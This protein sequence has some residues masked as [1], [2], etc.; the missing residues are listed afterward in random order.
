MSGFSYSED[1]EVGVVGVVVQPSFWHGFHCG[2]SL[3]W[4]KKEVNWGNQPH[5]LNDFLV[6]MK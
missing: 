5:Q 2:E 1:E 3:S 4:E 6:D